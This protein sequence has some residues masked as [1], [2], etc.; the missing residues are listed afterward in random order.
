MRIPSHP[1]FLS[2][3]V[4]LLVATLAVP[5]AA[6]SFYKYETADGGIAFTDDAKRIPAR[7]R[8]D[9]E[10]IERDG[11]GDFDRYTHV[12]APSEADH[13]GRTEA[14]VG[15]LRDFN[16]RTLSPD[17]VGA[18]APTPT[19]GLTVRSSDDGQDVEAFMNP[20]GDEP[21]IVETVRSRPDGSPVT[22]HITIV[23]QG[24]RV[25]SVIAPQERHSTPRALDERTLFE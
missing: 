15:H 20:T 7:Y 3:T 16:A 18:P 24:D 11:F 5:A 17:A 23:R 9:A 6:G 21:V 4:G 19:R 25:L 8:D 12:G 10:A 22:R 14:R 13:A 1:N 2:W